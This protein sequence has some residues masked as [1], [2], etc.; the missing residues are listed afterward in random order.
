MYK[1]MIDDTNVINPLV[2]YNIPFEPK[3]PLLLLNSFAL[4]NCTGL[5]EEINDP[6]KNKTTI[7]PWM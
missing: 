7:E 4:I 3:E 1:G 5:F 6:S 2:Q